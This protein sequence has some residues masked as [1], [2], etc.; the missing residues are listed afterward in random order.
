M[1]QLFFS[2]SP[3]HMHYEKRSLKQS[4][5]YAYTECFINR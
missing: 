1:N 3:Y 4:I 5:K 2:L